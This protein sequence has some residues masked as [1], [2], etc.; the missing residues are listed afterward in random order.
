LDFREAESFLDDWPDSL[1]LDRMDCTPENGSH[2][3]LDLGI[4]LTN[5]DEG[6]VRVGAV[7][8]DAV[9]DC[10]ADLLGNTTKRGSYPDKRCLSILNWQVDQVNVHR[11]AGQVT[12][13][14]V[15]CCTTLE[16]EASLGRYVWQ[17]TNE[18]GDLCLED[19]TGHR[20]YLQR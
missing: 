12:N 2:F 18:K 19:F 3:D 5:K 16:S 1:Q 11:E 13:E 20:C 15:D 8:D 14:K 6:S 10:F 9:K 17:Y 7:G 4:S